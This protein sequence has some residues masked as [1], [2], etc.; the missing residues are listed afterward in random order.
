MPKVR[1]LDA[2]AR[3]EMGF[4]MPIE[5][6]E[7]RRRSSKPPPEP[8]PD[9][10]PGTVQTIPALPK[11]THK[12]RVAAY[13]RVSPLHIDQEGSLEAQQ[14]HF[15]REIKSNPEYEFVD[16]YLDQGFTGT[17]ADIRPE[18][19]RMIEDCKAG[20]IDLI[21]T[22]SISRFS[23]N[24][25]ECLEMVRELTSLGVD[26]EFEKENLRTDAM[27][28]EIM[29]TLL[30]TYAEMESRSIS[31]NI[32]WGIR[33]RFRD[34][35]YLPA[36]ILY[37][38]QRGQDGNL[39]INDREAAVVRE[40]FHLI[41]SGY[42]LK[43]IAQYLNRRELYTRQGYLWTADQLGHM[44]KNPTY[45]GD[46][47]Y[48]RT[49]RDENYKQIVN[50]GELDQ[51]Y[52]EDCHPAIISRE[53]FE[54][55]KEM[56]NRRRTKENKVGSYLFSG[57]MTCDK[58]GCTMTRKAYPHRI[59][60][61][62]SSYDKQKATCQ[63]VIMEQSIRNAFL[64]V[65]NK[66]KFGEQNGVSVVGRLI[67]IISSRDLHAEEIAEIEEQ[68]NRNRAETEKIIAAGIA[69]IYR[70]ADRERSVVLIKEEQDLIRKKQMILTQSESLEFANR[71]QKAVREWEIT[72][73]GFEDSLFEELIEC[74]SV[75]DDYI[76]FH[77]RCGLDL[78]EEFYPA[79][80]DENVEAAS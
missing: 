3:F 5:E 10:P 7:K 1:T 65:M 62:C 57:V 63:N 6:I 76:V 21:L 8:I 58:C 75:G 56:L 51:Y 48:Q 42:G 49:Y 69:G 16:I 59:T 22:K 19:K 80:Q 45:I 34:G 33:K 26:I 23:R 28:T 70:M 12:P 4:Q 15:N 25:I 72:T 44:V 78:R 61:R 53:D 40:V 9:P 30:A 77:F 60:Y 27:T 54:R 29:L 50:H 36:L 32:K 14:E 17:K 31:E 66:L 64:T 18:L 13:G 2:Q 46:R 73:Y 74:M 47:L 52:D 38:Y 41:L 24:C 43:A 67:E 79:D 35:T 68:L 37:G 20:K 71:L 55:V 11:I 39:I